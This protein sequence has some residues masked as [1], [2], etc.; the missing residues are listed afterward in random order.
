MTT[1]SASRT[2]ILGG[3][4]D[5]IHVG[6]LRIAE[7]ARLALNLERVT[8][9]PA[10]LQWMKKGDDVAPAADR[11]EMV[12]LATEGN[13]QF[14]VSD[15]EIRR[16]GPSY[17]VDTLLSIRE[18]LGANAEVHFILGQD[19]FAEV[20]LWSRPSE[21]IELCRFAVMPRVDGPPI[22]LA[23]MDSRVPGVSLR[24]DVLHEAPRID[25][26]SSGLRGRLERG[27]DVGG[28]VP[29]VV[30]GYIARRGLYRATV[31]GPRAT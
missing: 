21:L 9:V 4:F 20:H 15:L 1:R 24:T 28:L 22:D 16:P 5:P 27:E 11:L 19:A 10:G 14:D 6:H 12:R 2:G 26:S 3:S 17:T 25:V 29:D 30:V 31:T 23:D 7:E 13:D 8:F 18:Q